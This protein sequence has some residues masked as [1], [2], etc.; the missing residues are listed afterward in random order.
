MI[1]PTFTPYQ[2]ACDAYMKGCSL[3]TAAKILGCCIVTTRK[4]LVAANIPIRSRGRRG[5]GEKVVVTILLSRDKKA[6]IQ[7]A[8]K[9]VNQSV[10]KLCLTAVEK[11]IVKLKAGEE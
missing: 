1:T 8:A 6:A 5:A 4:Y 7:E 2:K 11:W 10:T 3:R 9:S